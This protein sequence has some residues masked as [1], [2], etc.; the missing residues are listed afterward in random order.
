MNNYTYSGIFAGTKLE[1]SFRHPD[2]VS[3]FGSFLKPDNSVIDPIVVPRSDCEYWIDNYHMLDNGNTEFGMSVYRASDALLKNNTFI[4]HAGAM[5]WNKRVYLFAADSG[6]GKSTQLSLWKKLYPAEMKITNGDKPI[7]KMEKDYSF[8]VYPSP[9]K[10]KED[11]GDDSIIA[12]L[13]GIILLKQGSTNSITLTKPN[14]ISPRLLTYCF[15]TFETEENL[16]R[17]CRIAERLLE[18]VPVWLL[19]N[20]GDDDSAQLTH[21][22]LLE[23]V[24]S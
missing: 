12:P 21:Q 4:I 5:L 24:N 22:T 20:K 15:S 8:T 23:T 11:W 7:L 13:G 16:H 6:T 3:N 1:F 18:A 2:T 19:V 9:W 14:S 17:L 10:G